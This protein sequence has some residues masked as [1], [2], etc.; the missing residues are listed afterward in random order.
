MKKF[1]K[2]TCLVLL[3][4]ELLLFYAALAVTCFALVFILRRV[5][6]LKRIF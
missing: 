4:A 1:L 2:I 5:P 6:V 3:V